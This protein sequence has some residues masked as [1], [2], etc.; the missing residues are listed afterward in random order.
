[1]SP[2]RKVKKREQCV[3]VLVKSGNSL[4]TSELI[5]TPEVILS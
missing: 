2:N 4:H 3:D 5:K 1:M